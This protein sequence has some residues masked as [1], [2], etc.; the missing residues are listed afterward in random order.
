MKTFLLLCL[1]PCHFFLLHQHYHKQVSITDFVG[2]ILASFTLVLMVIYTYN[3]DEGKFDNKYLRYA[4]QGITV[5]VLPG[6][7]CRRCEQPR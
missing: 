1:V 6:K 2:L 3:Y 5:Y 7:H 4:E